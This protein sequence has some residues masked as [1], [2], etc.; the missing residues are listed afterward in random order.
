[1]INVEVLSNNKLTVRNDA[2]AKAV[3]DSVK[4][5]TVKFSFA[6]NWK[7]YLKTAVF[8][9]DEV[10]AINVALNRE[11]MM[12]ISE[13]ECYIPH[14]VLK[15]K[16]FYLSVYGVKGDSLATSTKVK[17]EVL[18]SG[19]AL[20][21]E[22]EEPTPSQYS[23]ILEMV[24]ETKGIAEKLRQDAQNGVF[25][26]EKGDAGEKGD[27]GDKGDPYILTEED[28][29][30]I[31]DKVKE[32]MGDGTLSEEEKAEM[33]TEIE[34]IKIN[35][36]TKQYVADEIETFLDGVA[37]KEYVEGNYVSTTMLGEI[38]NVLA[39]DYATKEYVNNI[40][41]EIETLLGGI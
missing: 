13:D 29:N 22:P 15:G 24:N 19:Y 32:N 14:E 10:D 21:D 23:Q 39:D 7:D 25:T 3:S 35:Y 8:S 34:D 37:T 4:H 27:K 20:G 26:G 41:G 5:E 16:G 31:A 18:E 6:D 12:C 36:A 38:V 33:L 1:M 28:K 17:I 9:T 40:V 11:N 2:L 30:E